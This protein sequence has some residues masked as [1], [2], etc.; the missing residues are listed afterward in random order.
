MAGG[1]INGRT[2]CP[3]GG[4]PH[5]AALT[6]DLDEALRVGD[7]IARD[8]EVIPQG[9]SQDIVLRPADAYFANFVKEVNQ[10]ALST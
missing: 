7:H 8:G 6:H 9:A 4:L 10:G 3:S 2:Q 5:P 1:E